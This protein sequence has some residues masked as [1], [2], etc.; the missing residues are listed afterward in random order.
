MQKTQ[1][2]DGKV[3]VVVRRWGGVGWGLSRYQQPQRHM[4]EWVN[5]H[6]AVFVS[7]VEGKTISVPPQ[8]NVI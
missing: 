4:A 6:N 3:G 8:R 1:R 2:G 5:I 7:R